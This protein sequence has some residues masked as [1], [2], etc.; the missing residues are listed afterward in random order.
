M[1]K[2]DVWKDNNREILRYKMWDDSLV[3][4]CKHAKSFYNICVCSESAD[5]KDWE[6]AKNEV[7]FS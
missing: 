6:A 5:W 4:V 2:F 7:Y 3:R 1:I